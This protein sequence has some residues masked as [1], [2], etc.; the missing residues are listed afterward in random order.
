MQIQ[1]Q[2][3]HDHCSQDTNEINLLKEKINSL[4]IANGQKSA[5][6]VRLTQRITEQEL[7][8]KEE[9]IKANALTS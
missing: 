7:K 1:A 3:H 4:E 5:E 6:I 9:A 2:V 8:I